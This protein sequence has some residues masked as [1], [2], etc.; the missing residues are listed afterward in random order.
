[1]IK[2]IKNYIDSADKSTLLKMYDECENEC[3]F[4]KSQSSNLSKNRISELIYINQKI[5]QKWRN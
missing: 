2:Q 1:M 4:L 3:K 5:N